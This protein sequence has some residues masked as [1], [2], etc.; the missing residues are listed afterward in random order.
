MFVF[1]LD[2]IS[3][4]RKELMGVAAISIILCHAPA[5]I[6][7][8]NPILAFLLKSLGMFGNPTFF[9]LSGVGM[10]FSL[11]RKNAISIYSWYQKRFFEVIHT[12]S[13][14]YDYCTSNICYGR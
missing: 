7:E 12:V 1:D 14:H 2:L 3:K 13:V 4:F 11:S 5:N 6:P 10:Y 8:M 9:F